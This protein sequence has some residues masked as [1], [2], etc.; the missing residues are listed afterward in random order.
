[1]SPRSSKEKN[2]SIISVWSL[3]CSPTEENLLE[4]IL[5]YVLVL[6]LA[7]TKLVS[8]HLFLL[9][10]IDGPGF[11]FFVSNLVMLPG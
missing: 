5:S 3:I 6:E 7:H 9:S 4:S 11:T 1:M 2:I 10:H 8:K